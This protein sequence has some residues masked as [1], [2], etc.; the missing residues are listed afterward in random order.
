MQSA[1]VTPVDQADLNKAPDNAALTPA[2]TADSAKVEELQN[3]IVE[4]K[5]TIAQLQSASVTKE[6][7]AAT[8]AEA[9]ANGEA[10]KAHRSA[11]HNSSHHRAHTAGAAHGNGGHWVLRAAKPGVAWVAKKGS[12]DLQMVNVGD[13]LAGVGTVTSISQDSMGQWVIDGSRGHIHQ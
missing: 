13:T 9:A 2:P 11:R 6:D 8:S 7:N 1:P 10:P 3:E 12:D 4:L 5:K